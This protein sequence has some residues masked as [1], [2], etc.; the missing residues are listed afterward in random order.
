MTPA[1]VDGPLLAK[2]TVPL[3]VVAAL[4]DAGTES[5]VVTSAIAEIAV[6]AVAL[7]GAAL[8]PSLVDVAIVE[9]MVTAPL[10]GAVYA[11]PST[12]DDP[13][14]RLDGIP[15]KLTAPLAAS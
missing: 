14:P 10:V 8:A 3:T 9:L 6:V 15:L 7:S 11:T 5:D 4:A 13:A 12:I 1:A 2:V